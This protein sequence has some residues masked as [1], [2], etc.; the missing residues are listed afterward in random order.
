MGMLQVASWFIDPQVGPKNLILSHLDEKALQ[1]MPKDLL[2]NAECVTESVE[3]MDIDKSKIILL[4]PSAT[5]ELTP[6]DAD[7]CDYMLFGGIL[8]DIP[9]IDR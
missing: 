9:S 2:E 6:A 4:D 3:F 1:D 8:G 5:E 7:S